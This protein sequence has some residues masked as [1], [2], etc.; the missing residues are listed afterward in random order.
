M[1]EK[2]G[3]KGVGEGKRKAG[4]NGVGNYIKVEFHNE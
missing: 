2:K 1:K 4:G 3:W